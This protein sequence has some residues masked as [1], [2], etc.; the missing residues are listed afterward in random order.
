MRILFLCPVL[1]ASSCG[2]GGEEPPPVHDAGPQPI[3]LAAGQAAVFTASEAMRDTM[4]AAWDGRGPLRLESVEVESGDS[5]SAGDTLATG[6][7]SLTSLELEQ[8][9]MSLA[10]AEAGGSHP[11]G[12]DSERIDLLTRL[13]DS[14]E[15]ARS[16]SVVS[17]APGRV[18][19]GLPAPG[20]IL[21]PGA[22]LVPVIMTPRESFVLHAPEGAEIFSWP[23]RASDAVLV[24]AGTES[25][26]Y[27]G[28][29]VIG[30]FVFPGSVSVP[31]QALRDDG[32]G[33]YVITEG[34]DSVSV[35]RICLSG[36]DVTILPERP[37]EGARIVGWAPAGEG[38]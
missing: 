21:M 15:E 6:L 18:G 2:G 36:D 20:A 32:L 31:R 38:K 22:R 37:L 1:I 30:D 10:F 9:S 29:R 28:A 12:A 25:A 5:V 33:A 13:A 16:V 4:W 35:I 27:S 7:D 34:S 19:A 24:E 8:V 14:L 3:F 17:P 11:A 23:E 26:L